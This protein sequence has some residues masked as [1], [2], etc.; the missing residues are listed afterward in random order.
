[1]T[2][3]HIDAI[4][5]TITLASIGS[6]G[7][8]QPIFALALT[9]RKRGHTVRM[10]VPPNFVSWISESGIEARPLGIDIQTW[11]NTHS[12][13]L[14]GN[15]IRMLGAIRRFFSEQLPPQFLALKEIAQGSDLVILGGLAFSGFSVAE[16]LSIRGYRHFC[17]ES[18]GNCEQSQR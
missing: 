8:V 13:Y 16:A 12:H 1:M 4:R 14:S 10:A 15:P 18:N 5:R 17:A 9:L 7:D 3:E 11:L 2:S 6:R